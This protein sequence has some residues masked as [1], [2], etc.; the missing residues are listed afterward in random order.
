VRIGDIDLSLFFAGPSQINAVV[1]FGVPLGPAQLIVE[2]QGATTVPL[3]IIVVPTQPGIFTSTQTGS[4]QGSILIG[5]NLVDSQHPAHP[6][7]VVSIYCA[8][9]GAVSPATSVDQ[10]APSMEPL[11]RVTGGVSVLIGN[12]SAQVYFAGLAPGYN[13]LYQI[14][15]Q[16][17]QGVTAG[18]SVPVRIFVDGIESNTV[19]IAVR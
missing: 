6:G 4:G 13:G 2:N 17:P 7:D 15:A 16:I 12:I 11:P 1:P 3:P 5:A 14:N 19:A 10:P 9:L 18:L 8:G